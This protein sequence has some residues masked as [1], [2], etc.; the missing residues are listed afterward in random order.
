MRVTI[1]TKAGLG[2]RRAA[3]MT[4]IAVA[5]LLATACSGSGKS[6]GAGATSAGSS[7]GAS[8]SADLVVV[9]N[10]SFSPMTL[11]V[12]AGTKVTWKF[13]DSA[14]HTVSADD[15]SFVSPALNSGQTYSFT[16]ATP[17]TYQYICSIHQYMKGTV[18]VK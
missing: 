18:I 15:K 11:T 12:A 6:T 10:F 8:V 9:K 2:I 14:Q 7:S 3:I 1:R 5:A 13:E 17:G 4:V 16:F